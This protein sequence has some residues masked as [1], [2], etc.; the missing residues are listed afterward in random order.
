MAVFVADVYAVQ[1]A[2]PLLYYW[3]SPVSDKGR[4]FVSQS[5]RTLPYAIRGIRFSKKKKHIDIDNFLLDLFD[6][7]SN[8]IRDI[9]VFVTIVEKLYLLIYYIPI[10]LLA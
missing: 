8:I 7:F 5:E 4:H 2:V 3:S 6:L 9:P 10:M 1:R